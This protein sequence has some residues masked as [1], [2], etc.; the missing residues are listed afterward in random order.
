MIGGPCAAEQ[1][2]VVVDRSS[3]NYFSSPYRLQSS[4]YTSSTLTILRR[5]LIARGVLQLWL[6]SFSRAKLTP[7][8]H[9]PLQILGTIF[10]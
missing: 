10:R 5:M 3:G 1:I 4:K 6:Q 8:F 2:L 7:I 9:R